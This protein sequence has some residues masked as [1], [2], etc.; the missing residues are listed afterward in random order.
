MYGFPRFGDGLSLP[1]LVAWLD[2]AD[3]DR[4]WLTARSLVVVGSN[5]KGSTARMAAAGLEAL[6]LRTGCFTSPHMFDP[7][8]RITLNGRTISGPDLERRMAAVHAWFEAR[9]EFGRPGG[10][11]GFFLAAVEHF[12]EQAAEAMVW[13]AGIGG[14]YDPVRAAGARIAAFT[15]LELE[16]V[17]L[18]GPTLEHIAYDKIDALAPGGDLIVSPAIPDP[19]RGRFAAWCG[20]AGRSC[21]FVAD[22][23]ALHSS[24]N[25]L[26]GLE[27]VVGFRGEPDPW[28]ARLM[29]IGRHQAMN[30]LTAVT[31]ASALGERLRRRDAPAVRRAV[32]AT[33][34]RGRLERIPGPP[35]LWI[36]VG[37]TPEA[38]ALSLEALGDVLDLAQLVVVFGASAAK[39]AAGM[40]RIVA[41]RATRVILTRPLHG[42][43][44]P[45][46]LAP[47]FAG[48]H[49]VT[50]EP[51]LPAAVRLARADAG[52]AGSAAA[53]GG[54]FLA[55][56]VQ[57]A[58]AGG[59]PSRLTFY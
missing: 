2:A 31:A 57:T 37:H 5:G 56:E 12:R 4:S 41:A 54:L 10:F 58:W 49:S 15:A 59:D 19:W 52:P 42:G 11:E 34:W 47:L 3:V 40:A 25:T 18:L 35:D 53:I 24:R 23:A 44:D 29:M 39:D 38:V 55:A 46:A 33:R 45:L 7:V 21:R 13:E 22:E 6:G 17:Q 28:V 27:I 14:R 51:D 26:D 1:R 16:H 36:D 9:P 30:A 8:E 20:V 43:A 48:A 32:A 50:I